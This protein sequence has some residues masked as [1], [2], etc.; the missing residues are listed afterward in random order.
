MHLLEQYRHQRK[1]TSTLVVVRHAK[2]HK[3]GS[4][5]GPDAERPLNERGERQAQALAPILHAY[6]VARVLSS[7]STRCIQ[8]VQPYASERSLPVVEV[9]ALSE[10]GYDEAA[11]R[12]L[13]DELLATPGPSVLC[14][15]RP[16][17]PELF[18]LLGITEEP[19]SPA[20]RAALRHA[21]GPLTCGCSRRICLVP[22]TAASD[23]RA[24]FIS[25]SP[26]QTD[27]VTCP[28]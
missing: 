23:G 2:A 5:D 14:S 1:S 7:P 6:G 22:H 9:V 13:L 19:L 12:K 24:P 27:P 26:A 28:S 21:T 8:T 11:A 18:A 10:E 20:D 15:H 17:L 3:R 16:V 25:R 4:W